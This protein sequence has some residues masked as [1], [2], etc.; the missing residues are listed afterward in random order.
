MPF[1]LF[2]P[3]GRRQVVRQWILIPP[4]GGS[5]PPAPAKDLPNEKRLRR[6]KIW[7]AL[8]PWSARASLS[9]ERA[10]PNAIGLLVV[11]PLTDHSPTGCKRRA[12]SDGERFAAQCLICGKEVPQR[13]TNR[14]TDFRCWQILFS[15]SGSR[16]QALQRSSL[17]GPLFSPR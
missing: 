3:L 17:P 6:L 9:Q 15:N 13:L 7:T 4:Y 11:L 14:V 10:R 8:S 2:R 12:S 16:C 1:H 5:N